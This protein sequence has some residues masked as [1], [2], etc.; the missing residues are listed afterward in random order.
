MLIYVWYHNEFIIISKSEITKNEWN[1]FR[2]LQF[3][4]ALSKHIVPIKR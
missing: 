3:E 1:E 2:Y 4:S